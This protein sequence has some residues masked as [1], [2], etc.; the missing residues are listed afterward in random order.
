[1]GWVMMSFRKQFLTQQLSDLEYKQTQLMQQLQELHKY[2]A[3]IAD[4]RLDFDEVPGLPQNM[5]PLALMYGQGQ[6]SIYA[7]AHA[8]IFGGTT[9]TGETIPGY[10]SQW[11]AQM[12]Q[13][14]QSYTDDVYNQVGQQFLNQH[15]NSLMQE[16]RKA[17]EARIKVIED[18]INQQLEKVKA[19]V[20]SVSSELQATDEGIDGGIKRSTP[21]Y[22]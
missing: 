5:L 9:A 19:Q 6:S 11:A 2:S 22:A 7:Q 1:M 18:D 8:N 12:Q 15:F 20:K 17:E 10:M 14:G 16:A 3:T 21:K 4:G 13:M